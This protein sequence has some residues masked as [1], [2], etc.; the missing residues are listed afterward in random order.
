M[1]FKNPQEQSADIQPHAEDTLATDRLNYLNKLNESIAIAEQQNTIIVDK[2]SEIESL[3]DEI[4]DLEQKKIE[5][6]DSVK[7]VEFDLIGKEDKI[8]D[9]K[10]ELTSLGANKESILSQITELDSKRVLKQN[11]LT[12]VENKILSIEKDISN[13]NQ[14]FIDT[15]IN[16][17]SQLNSL[18]TEIE[19]KNKEVNT[20]IGHITKLTE[21]KVFLEE[22]IVEYSKKLDD[23]KSDILE[24]EIKRSNS[25]KDLDQLRNDIVAE[26]QKFENAKSVKEL[27]LK[28][29]EDNLIL[30][31][32]KLS[33]KES[34]LVSKEIQLKEIKAEL[35]KF[36]GK[37]I[38]SINF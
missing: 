28:N 17:Q 11:K 37:K 12:E 15:R 36:Y 32:G 27:D 13:A 5:I 3:E 6:L 20:I 34:W 7:K 14:L 1:Q 30:A 19:S 29:R 25:Q 8:K 16:I 33:D 4:S 24:Q 18:N 21:E 2:T 26:Q 35:E 23:I 10:D 38:T 9:L 22:S 31:E